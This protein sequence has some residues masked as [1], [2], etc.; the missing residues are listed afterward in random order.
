[1]RDTRKHTI[2]GVNYE[3]QQL[4]AKEGRRV[5]ARIMRAVAGAAGAAQGQKDPLEA[6]AAGASKLAEALTDEEIDFLCDTFAKCTQFE[7]A[8]GKLLLLADQFDDH[9]AGRYGA[10]VKWLWAAMETNYSSFLSDL[11]LNA[12]ADGVR[13]AMTGLTKASP[14]PLSG[15]SSSPASGA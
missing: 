11:G 13:G 7:P 6:A 2:N 9:F 8:P 12:L 15:D 5:L 14:T 4:G 10:M 1:M 3:I